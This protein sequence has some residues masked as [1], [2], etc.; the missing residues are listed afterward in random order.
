MVRTKSGR[1][2]E[3]TILVSK[4]EYDELQRIAKEGGDPAKILSKYM[5]KDDKVEGWTK[6]ALPPKPMKVVKTMVRTKSGRLVSSLI[7]R[8]F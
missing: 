3:K 6:V 2:V 7:R 1:L 5:S 4:E 8:E